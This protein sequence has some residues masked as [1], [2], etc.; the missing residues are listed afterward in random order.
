MNSGYVVLT[1]AI[2]V[3]GALVMVAA[4]FYDRRRAREIARDPSRLPHPPPDVHAPHPEDEVRRPP[5]P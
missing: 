4:A 5:G 1:I 2:L 3:I